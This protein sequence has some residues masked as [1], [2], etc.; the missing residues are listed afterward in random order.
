MTENFDIKDDIFERSIPFSVL[1]DDSLESFRDTL[2]LSMS[3]EE[4]RF[5]RDY[6]KGKNSAKIALSTLRFLDAISKDAKGS[7]DN[8][9]ITTLKTDHK[10]IFDSYVDLVKKQSI[11]SHCENRP[12]SLADA[13]DVANEYARITRKRTPQL[14]SRKDVYTPSGAPVFPHIDELC[15]MRLELLPATAFVLVSPASSM[16]DAEYLRAVDNFV[17]CDGLSDKI[18][19]ARRIS[20]GGIVTALTDVARGVLVDF[21]AIPDMPEAADLSRLVSDHRGRFILALQKSQIEFA[22]AISEYYG[23]SISYFAKAI[24]GE[25]FAFVTANNIKDTVD[26]PI[27]R[28][29]SHPRVELSAHIKE[30]AFA[31]PEAI[32]LTESGSGGTE[33]VL[34]NGSIHLFGGYVSSTRAAR[35][36]DAPF[37]AAIQTALGAMLPILSCGVSRS[38][39]W[40]KLKYTLA[41]STDSEALGES[42]SAMLG[43]Y[44]VMSELYLSG[45]SNVEYTSASEPSISV[46]AFS[47]SKNVKVLKKLLREH[48]GVYLLSFDRNESGMPSFESL[49]AMCDFYLEC[50]RNKYVLSSAAVVGSIKDTLATMRSE[51]ECRIADSATPFLSRDVYGIIVESSTP[52]RHGVFLGSTARTNDEI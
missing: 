19:L 1:T 26:T 14:L 25:R 51:F 20:H 3:C 44:R 8:L 10:D 4:I 6:Y 43:I 7:P 16:S 46:A 30:G 13:P 32:T 11:L 29:L 39:V 47:D 45:E 28:K 24:M 41:D 17:S 50:L 36:G 48:S 9:Y 35:L 34:T 52:L 37:S 38:D 2:G 33:R 15:R 49:R 22:S 12:I 23:L 31:P 18:I 21:F 27:I 5:C 42:L 40:L